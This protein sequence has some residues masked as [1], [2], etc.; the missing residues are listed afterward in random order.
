[1]MDSAADLSFCVGF[2][3]Q[4]QSNARDLEQEMSPHADKSNKLAEKR[5]L[6]SLRSLRSVPNIAAYAAATN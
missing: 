1:M 3:Q 5:L 2:K 4:Q 6:R